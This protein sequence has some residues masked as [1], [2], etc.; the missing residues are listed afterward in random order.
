MN[1]IFKLPGHA[2]IQALYEE[3]MTRVYNVYAF[4]LTGGPDV[5]IVQSLKVAFVRKREKP[6][7]TA[8]FARVPEVSTILLVA[9]THKVFLIQNYTCIKIYPHYIL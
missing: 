6:P 4:F 8:A 9:T 1:Y 5:R 7:D 2:R 3:T